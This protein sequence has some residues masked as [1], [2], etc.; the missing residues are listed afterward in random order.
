MNQ[1]LS[2]VLTLLKL[3]LAFK[4]LDSSSSQGIKHPN[5]LKEGKR[6]RGLTLSLYKH[7]FKITFFFFFLNKNTQH[8]QRSFCPLKKSLAFE[9]P[10]HTFH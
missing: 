2:Q 10:T 4:H 1:R 8:S 5:Y 9:I 7:F 6:K 3:G